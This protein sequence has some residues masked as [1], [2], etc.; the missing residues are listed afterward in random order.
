M[1]KKLT[2]ITFFLICVFINVSGVKAQTAMCIDYPMKETNG[3]NLLIEGWV[4]SDTPNKE[5]KFYIDNVPIDFEYDRVLRN[6]VLNAVSGYGDSSLNPN[7]G[8]TGIYDVSEQKDGNHVLKIELLG[9]NDT[10]ISSIE[11]IFN[12]KKNDTLMEIDTPLSGKTVNGS[13]LRISGW[14]LSA[15]KDTHLSLKVNDKDVSEQ[16]QYIQREDVVNV[17]GSRYNVSKEDNI[18]FDSYIDVSEFKD[19]NIKI[20]TEIIDNKTGEII[21]QKS[22]EINLKKYD[23]LMEIDTPL[24]GKTA[25]GPSIRISGWYLSTSKDTH[26]SFKVN[27]KDVSEQLQYIQREDVVNVFG[28]RYNVSKEDNIGF[29]SYIDVSEFKDGNIKIETEIIDNK[30]GE[31]IGQ[32]S[33]EINLKKYEGLMEID[34]PLSGK[35]TKG[36]SIRISG[37]YLS[38]SKDTH[39]SLKVND[40]DVSEQL[41]YIQ[42]E[43]VVNVYGDR[44][45]ADK[46][47]NIGFDSYIDVSEFKDGNIKIETEIIDNK[48]GEI[49]GKKTRQSILK[50]YDGIICIDYPTKKN[51]NKSSNITIQGW[52]LSELEDSIIKIKID[53][54]E[55]P[56]NRTERPDV[57]NAYGESYGGAIK[58]ATPGFTTSLSL[59]GFSEGKHQITIELYTKLNEKINEEKINFNIYEN[60]YYGIDVSSHQGNI[61]W[62]AVAAEGIDFVI[63]RM[64]Y[65][66]NFTHQDDVQ[67]YNNINGAVKNG[68]PY[69]LYLYSYANV[70]YGDTGLNVDSPSS[71]S[72]AAHALRLLNSLSEYQKTQLKLP[73][74]IDMEEEKNIFV[75][76]PVL[77]EIANNFCNIISNNGY[78]CG[79]YA[80]KNWLYN[81]LDNKM[82]ESKYD[83]WLAHYVE[84]TDYNSMFQLWQYSSL[85]TLRGITSNG[86][87]LNISYKRYW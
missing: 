64:G 3:K 15:V 45:N 22:R 69:G 8:F 39:L 34:T 83:I 41:Q 49:I 6:D 76:K 53:G 42:R 16:L 51:F 62:D 37:W 84:N 47:D 75:G 9:D 33:R 17:Y 1:R 86:L 77:T 48:T 31:I 52:E 13:N 55:Y 72:E 32:K 35:T 50:K 12:L 25:K 4:M 82:L 81:Y 29:D 74:F 70:V 40:K 67:L 14:Y 66:S 20:E 79:V 56:V 73:I 58:N 30:T 87:D 71:D 46:E 78:K 24:S 43:D 44:Y 60:S 27:G 11:R 68:I 21:G 28:S 61:N 5:L 26:L 36:P 59:T 7:P 23:G 38:T 54:N 10:I 63:I 57:I 65:G 2:Y 19:G 80:N 85:G 18:G